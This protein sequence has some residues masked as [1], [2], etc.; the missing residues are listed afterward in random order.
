VG[1]PERK[2]PLG[3]HRLRWEYNI[4]TVF[5]KLVEGQVM[6]LSDLR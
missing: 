1:K 4:T 3:K 2:R 6:D 5:N